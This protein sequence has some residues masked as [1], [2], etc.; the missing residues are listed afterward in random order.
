MELCAM[1]NDGAPVYP[2]NFKNALESFGE[3]VC[4]C[5]GERAVPLTACAPRAHEQM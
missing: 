4:C 1:V 3:G 5:W 2:G